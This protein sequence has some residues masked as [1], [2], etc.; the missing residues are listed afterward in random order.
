VNLSTLPSSPLIT[1][2]NVPQANLQMSIGIP[3]S[4]SAAGT[5]ATVTQASSAG[6]FVSAINTTFTA[7]TPTPIYNLVA[8]GQYDSAT[9]TFNASQININTY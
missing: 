4:G 9:N 6:A 2:A 7:S 5:D 1:T 3:V 8:V